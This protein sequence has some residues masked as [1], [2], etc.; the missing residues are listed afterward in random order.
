MGA[1]LWKLYDANGR[2]WNVSD[3]SALGPG[4]ST[5][6]ILAPGPS[7]AVS[8]ER[9]EMFRESSEVCE[10]IIFLQ[11]ELE[12]GRITGSTAEKV[13]R[14]LDARARSYLRTW[15]GMNTPYP[16]PYNDHTVWRALTAEV[17]GD[18]EEIYAVCAEVEE[19]N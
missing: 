5:R 1:D 10:A 18:N 7:G 12:E 15:S 16:P 9:F 6:A 8:T 19:Q 17:V 14:L 4:C 13:N 2:A 3:N 11:R